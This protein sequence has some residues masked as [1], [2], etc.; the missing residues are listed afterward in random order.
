M[1]SSSTL[2]F[3]LVLKK[4]YI[5]GMM[6]SVSTNENNTPPTITI[7][8]GIRLVDASPRERANGSAPSVGEKDAEAVE[9]LC[10]KQRDVCTARA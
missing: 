2:F 7:P 1:G 9:T 4:L 10:V 5:A 3:F 6:K 8:N